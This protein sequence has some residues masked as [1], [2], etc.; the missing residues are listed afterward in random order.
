[1]LQS[2]DGPSIFYCCSTA[3][4]SNRWLPSSKDWPTR[5]RDSAEN[6]VS[7]QRNVLPANPPH[8]SGGLGVLDAIRAERRQVKNPCTRFPLRHT[9]S[10][11][12]GR[13]QQR[14]DRANCVVAAPHPLHHAS[15]SK[16]CTTPR[17]LRGR[18]SGRPEWIEPSSSCHIGVRHEF[19]DCKS[20]AQG[21]LLNQARSKSPRSCCSSTIARSHCGCP[22]LSVLYSPQP[23]SRTQCLPY[24]WLVLPAECLGGIEGPKCPW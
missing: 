3:R 22:E 14:Q 10:P 4:G 20:R 9:S 11:T 5:L 21:K 2:C 13:M 16:G 6:Q 24:D 15:Q 7:H 12:R 17:I 8:T 18:L 19:L 23:N 1:M